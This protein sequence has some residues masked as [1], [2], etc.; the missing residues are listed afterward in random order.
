MNMLKTFFISFRVI[1]LF[2]IFLGSSSSVILANEVYQ[3]SSFDEDDQQ[4]IVRTSIG[5]EQVNNLYG[6]IFPY[7]QNILKTK[8]PLSLYGDFETLSGNNTI[9]SL[10]Y[11][12]SSR[13]ILPS[14]GIK[15]IIFPFHIFL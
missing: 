10:T 1:L 8:A 12:K 13:Y 4:E 7:Q 14:L 3:N 5:C 11:S 2:L 6:S 9:V 15:E